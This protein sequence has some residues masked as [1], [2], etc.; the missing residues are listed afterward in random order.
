[1]QKILLLININLW[2]NKDCFYSL[3]SQYKRAIVGITNNIRANAL[4]AGSQNV[5]AVHIVAPMPIIVLNILLQKK[6]EIFTKSWSYLLQYYKM[7]TKLTDFHLKTSGSI[8][9]DET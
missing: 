2:R 3:S 4:I 8:V 9:W 6:E 1:M 5:R 7:S